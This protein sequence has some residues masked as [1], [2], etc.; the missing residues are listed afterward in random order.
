MISLLLTEKS[1]KLSF[2]SGVD[3]FIPNSLA[4]DKKTAV[5]SLSLFTEVKQA[6]KYSAG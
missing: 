5:L 4:S 6:A 3:T 1:S 2:M